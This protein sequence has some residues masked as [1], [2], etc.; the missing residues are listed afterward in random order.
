MYCIINVFTVYSRICLLLSS[1]CSKLRQCAVSHHWPV[2]FCLQSWSECRARAGCLGRRRG[3][4]QTSPRRSPS[5]CQCEC[6]CPSGNT[7]RWVEW[8]TS[9]S[10]HL[11]FCFCFSAFLTTSG[12]SNLRPWG[13]AITAHPGPIARLQKPMPRTPNPYIFK[14]LH[15]ETLER[16]HLP[17]GVCWEI[18]G[19][20]SN[21][22]CVGLISSSCKYGR[23]ILPIKLC[24]VKLQSWEMYA[25][26]HSYKK[27]QNLP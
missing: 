14:Q 2:A 15:S 20:G 23:V 17:K 6:W 13:P 3:L 19:K 26:H 5:K 7:P 18:G 1:V 27:S 22:I 11:S 9:H 8:Y 24:T 10:P 16:V 4:S 21:R 12:W 25:T